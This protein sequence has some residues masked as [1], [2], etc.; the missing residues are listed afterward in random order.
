MRSVE[1]SREQVRK[2]RAQ[3]ET[4]RSKPKEKI[5][6]QTPLP[7]DLCVALLMSSIFRFVDD[8]HLQT[9]P[10]AKMVN[11]SD[12]VSMLHYA[13]SVLHYPSSQCEL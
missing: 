6:G 1:Q 13:S 10:I 12:S 2:R 5:K 3:S 8:P 4:I 9:H 11:L 7:L